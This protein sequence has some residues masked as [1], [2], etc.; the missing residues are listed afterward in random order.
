[1]YSGFEVC[2]IAFDW[3]CAQCDS[4]LTWFKWLYIMT[5]SKS[6]LHKQNPLGALLHEFVQHIAKQKTKNGGYTIIHPIYVHDT[7][8]GQH[9]KPW[10]GRITDTGIFRQNPTMWEK[11]CHKASPSHHHFIG[12]INLPFPVMGGK[13]AL[14]YS[15]HINSLVFGTGVFPLPPSPSRRCRCRH[16]GTWVPA[17]PGSDLGCSVTRKTKTSIDGLQIGLI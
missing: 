14:F 15:N 8:N 2:F 4:G 17:C 7:T 9:V 1:M 16:L 6:W 11:Q 5:D 10:D 13:L 12:G 3:S